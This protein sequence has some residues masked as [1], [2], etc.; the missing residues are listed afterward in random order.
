M[1]LITN[2]NI[3]P[4][5]IMSVVFIIAFCCF[6]N[7]THAQK[8]LESRQSSHY[9][10]I[11][12]ITNEEAK[13]IYYAK[14]TQMDKS[15]FHTLI[16][17][18]PTGKQFDEKLLP[19]HYLKTYSEKNIQKVEIT[20]VQNI[21]VFLLNN[22]Q[23]LVIQ[24]YDLNGD[25]VN[26]A[27]VKIKNKSIAY[28]NEIEAYSLKKSNRNGFL[29]VTYNETTAFYYLD[30]NY[31]NSALKR[32]SKK[33]VYGTPLRYI[34]TPIEFVVNLPIDG[35][36]S[37]SERWSQGTI[38]RAESF[39]V[40]T[41]E[42]V[43]CVF[44]DYYCKNYKR[45]Y[46]NNYL[47]YLVL[48][49]PKYKPN[50]T[51]KF[52]SFIVTKKGK[53]I[54]KPLTVFLQGNQQKTKITTLNPYDKGAYEFNFFLHD[55]LKLRL[56]THYT[57]YL[58]DAK[59]NNVM[60]GQFRYEDYELAKNNLQLRLPQK[61]HYNKKP[62][63]IYI[64]GTDENDLVLQDARV[65]VLLRLKNP[66]KYHEDKLFIPDTLDFIERKLEPVSETKIEISDSLFPSSNFE[67]EL[68][69]KLLTTDNELISKTKNVIYYHISEKLETDLVK[70]SL[71]FFY[72]KNGLSAN[73][74]IQVYGKDNFQNKTLIFEGETPV[75]I[76]L[77][78]FYSSYT[79]H[80]GDLEMEYNISDKPSLIEVSA[81]R[82]KD[83][84]KLEIYNPRNLF[85]NYNTFLKNKLISSGF[86]NE[87]RISKPLTSPQNYQI[88]IQYL[89]GGKV[90]N[91]DIT[92]PLRDKTLN[93]D[94][95]QPSLIYPGQNSTIELTVTDYE[96]NPV[97]GVDLTAFS[98]TKKFNYNMPRLPY[99]G[100][101]RKDRNVINTFSLNKEKLKSPEERS[102]DYE[103][104]NSL[105]SL[106]SLEH[107]KLLYPKNEIYQFTYTPNDSI[108]QF[109]PFV[110]SDGAIVPIHVIFV[111]NKPVY[112]SWSTMQQPYSFNI[113]E[114]YHQIKLRTA[115]KLIT[116]D[117]LFFPENKKLIFSIDQSI[118][119]K[120][121]EIKE[122]KNE[123]SKQ[124]QK[125]LYNY[126]F[127]YRN[128]FNNRFAYIQN[129][130]GVQLLSPTLRRYSTN[131]AGP[132]SGTV[133]YKD[134]DGTT[135]V[136]SHEPYFEY[137]FQTDLLKMRTIE[138]SRFPN[139]LNKHHQKNTRIQD[140]VFT[141]EKIKQIYQNSIQTSRTNK[142][143]FSNPTKTESGFGRLQIE[144]EDQENLKELPLNILIFSNDDPDFVRV[145]PGNARLF[146]QLS[147]T[148]YRL[149]F[150]Y[151]NKKYHAVNSIKIALNG[152]NFL[153]IQKPDELISDGFSSTIDQ[154]IK[155]RIITKEFNYRNYRQDLNRINIAHQQ[156]YFYGENVIKVEGTITDDEGLPLPGVNI[157][158]RGTTI[159]TQTDF[160]GNYSIL[161]NAGDVLVYS[162]VGFGSQ[163]IVPSSNSL[164]IKMEAGEELS[165]VIVTAFGISRE[166]KAL[167]YA[168]SEVAGEGAFRK[169]LSGKATG[170]AVGLSAGSDT[171]ITIRGVNSTSSENQPLYIVNGMIY[172]GDVKELNQNQ[173]I[174]I[175]TLQGLE[176][177]TLYGS[178]AANGVV[179]IEIND[180]ALLST[181]QL[182]NKGA[183]FDDAFYDGALEA[184]SLRQDFSDYAFWQP[185]LKTDTY[186]KAS[187]EAIFPDDITNWETFYLAMNG[188]KQ[189]GQLKKSI[190]SYKPLM[191]QLAVP[192]FLIENDTTYAI[193]KT[194]NYTPEE[195]EV[196][197]TYEIND[198]VQFSKK[199]LFENAII[200]TLMIT[201][202]DSISVKYIIEK[203]D[204][205]FDGELREIPVFPKGLYQTFGNFYVLDKNETIDLSF[206]PDYG[207]VNL[208]ARADILEVLDEEMNH[209]I[210]YRYLCNEQVASKLKMLLM[211][212]KMA[213][214]QNVP[215]KKEKDIDKLISLL[216]KNQK[217]S[218]V[219]GWWRDS[220]N[221][222]WIS[223][224]VLEALALAK[225]DGFSF[226]LNITSTTQ[227]MI[228]RL[229]NSSNFD[230]IYRIL[231]A[232]KLLDAK[233]DYNNYIE[234]LEKKEKINFN[235]RLKLTE[236]QQ[237]FGK[238]YQLDSIIKNK[239]LTLFGNIYFADNENIS[240]L[241]NNNIQNTILAYKIL[242][243]DTLDFSAEL[244]KMRNYF[245][246]RRNSGFWR[247]TYE[248][249]QIVETIIYDFIQGDSKPETPKLILEGDI[250]SV[251]ETFPFEMTV[252][253]NQKISISKTGDFPV[254]FT[255]YQSFWE[256]NPTENKGDFEISTQFGTNNRSVLKGGEEVTLFVKIK[257]E[258]DAEYVMIQ[259]PI[260]GGCS[261]GDNRNKG[262][263][264]SH[265]ENF[266][267]E[268][269][270]FCEKLPAGEHT[271][272]IKL[273]PRY[274]GNYT[275]NPA[276]IELMYFPTFNA[277]NALEKVS[278][279]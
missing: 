70:D 40:R 147:E 239:R 104:W 57:I 78:P 265:R 160:D 55:S 261:Y 197:I 105:A 96:G 54:D 141:P 228:W 245:F 113:R 215:F 244:S 8:L 60:S 2:I 268:T 79:A 114:G 71:T 279:E 72:R 52:K 69:V 195:Q 123:L 149:I 137:D 227:N 30:R 148:N 237:V 24:L 145:Y 166:K 99:L 180:K 77:L 206:N 203:A 138:K 100:K 176:A 102:I 254:Y 229:E 224:Q 198:V 216:L 93:I 11:F 221:S 48:N 213:E 154:I 58:E 34:W 223:L 210:K 108:T 271:F 192:R 56:D 31:N 247:N 153:R 235:E 146:H 131:F 83:S 9:T 25:I 167:G 200:D 179:I 26:S 199:A 133:V 152:L 134:F 32:V 156:Q 169:Q 91:E 236:L 219:W 194:L 7:L 29:Q 175:Q 111:D 1:L 253:P 234:K 208:Y 12:K 23:D 42:S 4:K 204:G 155:D 238:N 139:I 240:N 76:K 121:I 129:N 98:M 101:N 90:K 112:F 260:P 140:L 136:F 188:N 3:K 21:D 33:V 17:S 272:E 233:V 22:F 59:E 142:S 226:V 92:I 220:Q 27:D 116:I 157:I 186:G 232:L 255:S 190:K 61:N 143:Y 273:I 161:I 130:G 80:S 277:N 231:K 117:S 259:V 38:Q 44:D 151:P 218:G 95:E 212:K 125:S 103:Y 6:T 178:M 181:L 250:A 86:T 266:K 249:A 187:F 10:Y 177:T 73:R 64:K 122:V 50:D 47:G 16:D 28:N 84:I 174:S 43:A 258:K 68:L 159:G 106:D 211:Q 66:L 128:N 37:I 150:F 267:N 251:I 225:D 110:F 193:G 214:Y 119:K 85:F 246:E 19:G 39:F 252:D 209:V 20:T 120:G 170:I 182:K 63:E 109:A 45:R 18:F 163:E 158:V 183:E 124:E 184:G 248:S 274:S 132:I 201:A 185:Q 172:I 94:V 205:Y 164:N 230:E 82:T 14:Q 67:Y 263:F 65:Q 46:Y 275:L 5:T 87:L 127:P 171:Q 270:I 207:K 217:S 222:Y 269:A 144:I 257:M 168:V 278:I 135:K 53:P 165:Q 196:T 256:S 36:K 97:A 49:K 115:E 162:Y 202:K 81:V 118:S 241:L 35:F 88:S 262:R 173:I 191:A 13:K 41:Y 242:K 243:A 107:Y 51:V 75:Q 126:I 264:E 74:T 62:L 276:K 15:F 189:S 89:W